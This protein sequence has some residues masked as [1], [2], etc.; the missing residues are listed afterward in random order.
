MITLTVVAFNGQPADGSLHANFDELGGSIGRAE[1]NQLVLPDPERTISRVAA[2]VVFR[3]GAFAIVDRG[4]N[5]IVV[6]GRALGSGRE[7][8]LAPGD[9]VAIGG[10][11]L[12]VKPGG[13]ASAGAAA[14]DDPFAG[15]LGPAP[16]PAARG[17]RFVD[18]LEIV[19]GAPPAA[20]VARGAAAPPAGGIPPDWDPFAPEP[21]APGAPGPRPGANPLGLDLGAAPP[22]PLVAGMG[23]RAAEPSSLDQLFGLSPGRDGDPLADSVLDA[24]MAKPNTA[25]DEDDPMR[26]FG[27]APKGAAETRGDTLS[28]LQRPFIP[29]TAIKPAA[30]RASSAPP[31]TAVPAP[32]AMAAPAAVPGAVLS[33]DAGDSP[34]PTVI[35]SRPARP[36]AAGPGALPPGGAADPTASRGESPA[37]AAAV[38]PPGATLK[39]ADDAA[40]APGTAPRA[41]PR[42]APVSETAPLPETAQRTAPA[43]PAAE[44]DALLEALRRGL[45]LAPRDLP[46]L[47]PEVMEAIGALLREAARGTV[48]LLTA[49][50]T[51]KR[52]LRAPTTTIVPRDNNPLKFSPDAEVA[53]QHLLN[54]PARGFLPAVPAMRDAYDDLRAHQIGFVA[55]MQAALDG[56]LQRFDPALLEA[57][58]TE[59]SLLQSMLPA[60]RRAR[61][62][63]VFTEH[64]ARIRADASDDFHTLFG[65]AFVEA[66]E[67]QID[68]LKSA[69]GDER[70]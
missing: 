36:P 28:D 59:K 10:Y 26:A 51:F 53:L 46:A 33:W 55:G 39:P 13:A 66:Y 48:D 41:A 45:G 22:A 68:R 58:L 62:W 12:A 9:R 70:P 3:N 23:V 5:P 64:Y 69:S 14:A 6:N 27:M 4:S 8:P 30:P 2:Q 50:A 67:A 15:L 31:P 24:P 11:E 60:A 43:P 7:S 18:P 61:L 32:A 29:P 56:V 52:E 16:A 37:P 57:R 47:T 54:P 42:A 63:E 38:R 20:P 19:T 49:R 40:P 34:S 35:H 44:G 25:A 1:T 21:A 65:K 17:A